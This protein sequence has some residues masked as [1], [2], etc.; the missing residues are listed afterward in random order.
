MVTNESGKIGPRCCKNHSIF[1]S[2]VKVE[3]GSTYDGTRFE[4]IKYTGRYKT[5]TQKPLT[6]LFTDLENSTPL[7]E[8]YPDDMQQVSARHD[9]LMREVIEQHGGQVVKTTGD[10]FHAVFESPSDGIAAA[11]TGQQSIAA[12]S[13]P[14]TI[15]P[16]KVRMG[17]HTGE[18]QEREGDYYGLEVNLAA[19]IMSL[20]YGG[21]ILLSETTTTLVKKTL[22]PDCTVTDLGEHRLKGIAS[23]ERIFQLC[24][25]DLIANFPPLKSLAAFKHN[26]PRQ[27]SSFIGRT[28]E[29]AEIKRLLKDT[30]LLTL[31]GPGGTGKTR[32][33]L[34]AAEE[35]IEDYS[36]GVWLVELAPLTDPDLIP[37]RVAAALHVQE[38]PGHRMLDTLVEYLR[39]KELLLLL[40]NV[41][42]L[43]RKSAEFAEHLLENCPKL[44]ILVTG[45]EAL[46]IA[47]ET[48]LQ[49]P[50]LSLPGIRGEVDPEEIHSSEGVQLFLER[51]YAVRPDF[52]LNPENA[53]PIA[54][55]VVRLDGI[56][57]AL[58]LA[59]ARLRMMTVEQIASRLNDRFRLLTGGRR[60]ALPRQQT[61]QAL[62]DWSWNLL[63]EQ[64]HILLRRLSVFSGGWTLEAAQSVTGFDPLDELEV[65]DLLE[66]LINKSLVTV[67]H[68]PEG[69]ARYGM[70]ES[71]HQ[72]AQNKL[73]EAGEGEILRNR[74]MD[75]FVALVDSFDQNGLGPE[76]STW[77]KR[78]A[79]EGDNLR[80]VFEWI[81]E[82]RPGLTLRFT[83]KLLQ[84][85]SIWINYREARSWLE[86]A[87][88]QARNLLDEN[89][90]AIQM[91]DFIRALRSQGWLLVTHGDMID[92]HSIL[93][94]SIQL[95]R[96]FDEYHLLAIALGM[97]AQA[98]VSSVTWE[99]IDQ[100]EEVIALSRRNGYGIE[101]IFVLFSAG[102]AYLIK[103]DSEKG[104]R[105]ITEVI[106]LVE[107][108][109]G[110]FMKSWV[111]Y[112][113]AVMAQMT[114][115]IAESEKYY[116]LAA[117]T[118]EKLGDQRMAATCRSEL[119]HLY[120]HEGRN[121][122]AAAIYRQTILTWQE[123]GHHAAVAHQLE[124]FAYLAITWDEFKNAAQ[125]LGAAQIAR[126]RL[127]SLS[128]DE[129]E[130]AEREDAMRRLGVELG[131]DELDR[132]IKKGGLMSLDEA[133]AFALKEDQGE[134]G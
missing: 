18:S 94:E 43:V 46:F 4:I 5:M 38:Q 72:Y 23:A 80:A 25:P 56:P 15:G 7:W 99:V 47:G 96:K 90:T 48:T 103:G 134:P 3:I 118:N 8:E 77:M 35:L 34:Q 6:F 105:Y 51:A 65:F 87:I 66:Q 64:E 36:D 12:E 111:Y 63:D 78:F 50:S 130:I 14:S 20:G 126:E 19:R 74:H 70:L 9:A 127:N 125:L 117:D 88:E 81:A 114:Q 109:D 11:L 92:G 116:S 52:S 58:E 45:R 60:T 83:G 91:T 49:I 24:H 62:I 128:T 61:L 79:L 113:Q 29:L 22:P 2:Q 31:L 73:F 97:K 67:Q 108:L 54:E 121:D 100:L 33:M 76:Y 119:A 95:A 89:N 106:D 133:V 1:G 115:E 107:K 123:Q 71:I 32:L 84:Y 69:E 40:D 129:K 132:L 75:H 86:L 30:S 13:W 37:E 101:L 16:P 27:P 39:R 85:D 102:Q 28:K 57:L 41:E 131:V 55:I 120:R 104:Q 44:K 21:Q 98:M 93:D 82:D 124:C 26:L 68:P 42:H 17:L 122:E 110:L 59:A 10:G 112:A 53:T